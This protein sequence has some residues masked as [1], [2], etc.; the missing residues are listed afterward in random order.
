GIDLGKQVAGRR[1]EGVVEVKDPGVDVIERAFG[2]KPG[3]DRSVRTWR[4]GTYVRHAQR[5]G[6]PPTQNNPFRPLPGRRGAPG[7][8]PPVPSAPARG[9]ADASAPGP[10]AP[11]IA[12]R[13]GRE[14]VMSG[15]VGPQRLDQP[16]HPFA[17][18][19]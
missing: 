9:P 15:D 17:L 16:V 2:W 6:S 10:A 3:S 8:A 13:G 19:H 11:V 4:R 14:R 7:N 5:V 1:I 18:H 12:P